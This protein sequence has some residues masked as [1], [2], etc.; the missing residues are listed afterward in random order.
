MA[1]I[2]WTDLNP[3]ERKRTYVFPG[4]ERLVLENVTKLEVR[5]SGKHRV[6]TKDGR[7]LFV[8]P[9]WLWIEL[10]MDNWTC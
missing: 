10:E 5:E 4:G 7:K 1:A 9:G 8:A 2:S 3:P 6:E